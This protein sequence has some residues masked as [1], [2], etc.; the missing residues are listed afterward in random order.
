MYG[1]VNKAIQD[2]I[3]SEFGDDQWQKI[4]NK[5]GLGIDHFASMHSYE[6]IITY[7]LVG[8]ASDVL[9]LS[10]HDILVNF[11]KYWVSFTAEEGY[12][13]LLE[14]GG[15]DFVAFLKN[16]NLLHRRVGNSYVNLNPPEFDC[17]EKEPGKVLLRYDAYR[18][19]LSSFVIGLVHGLG[20]HF[21]VQVEVEHVVKREEMGH[22]EYMIHY[23]PI[24]KAEESK[25]LI[26]QL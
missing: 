16:L 21:S 19:G 12:G 25:A 11:G 8:A 2:L 1:L 10:A 6:D 3:V 13:N 20:K 9:G 24:L 5:A 14:K 23:H 15:A 4:R 22:D 17:T 7:K 26:G 18:E